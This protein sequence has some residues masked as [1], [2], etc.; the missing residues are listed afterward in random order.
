M[1]SNRRI[2]NLE[3]F[4]EGFE[5]VDILDGNLGLDNIK[6]SFNVEEIYVEF[7]DSLDGY[8]IP[9]EETLVFKAKIIRL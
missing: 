1:A 5:I 8:I 7:S 2:Y 3:I 6:P 9:K 4:T